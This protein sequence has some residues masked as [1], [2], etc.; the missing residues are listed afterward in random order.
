MFSLVLCLT[1]HETM[2]YLMR[3]AKAV[4]NRRQPLKKDK[5][6]FR[7]TREKRRRLLIRV[8]HHPTGKA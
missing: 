7:A 3:E 4:R 2:K 1:R 8:Y 6:A 5:V